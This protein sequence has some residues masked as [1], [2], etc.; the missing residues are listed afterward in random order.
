MKNRILFSLAALLLAMFVGGTA[1]GQ[2]NIIISDTYDV[3]SSTTG[4]A[5]NN[6][7]NFG[8]DPPTTRMTGPAAADLRYIQTATDKPA[9]QY[10][11]PSTKL[12]RILADTGSGK[13]GR[14]TLSA[15]GT[16]PFNFASALGLA[17]ASPTNRA[18]Y[19]IKISMQNNST[20]TAKLSFG[21]GTVEGNV[22]SF[23]FGIQI[24]RVSGEN[25]YSLSKLIDNASS[26][27]GDIKVAVT[28]LAAGTWKTLVPF[29]IRV[30]DAGAEAGTNYHSRVRVSIDNGTN[31]IYDTATDAALTNGWRLDGPGRVIIWDQAGNTGGP[32]YYDNFSLV[33]NYAPPAPPERVWTGAG[34][35]DNW[36][37]GGNWG[38]TAP[39]SGEPLLFGL[40][41]RQANFNDLTLTT[42]SLTFSNGGFSLSGN[43]LEVE[44][45]I[46]NL[47]GN[48]TIGLALA[49]PLPFAKTWQL[50]NGT[51]LN[52]SGF[53]TLNIGGDH[54]FY[55]GGTLRITGQLDIGP[56][57]PAINLTEG[58]FVVDGGTF[59]SDGG[60]R[61]GSGNIATAP[62]EV[63]VTNGASL[64]LRL[65]AGNLRVG[66][67]ATAAPSRLIVN[68]GTVDMAAGRMGI[69][70]AAG[71][72]AEVLQTGGLVTDCY[73][74]FNDEGA[75]VGT[76][77]VDGGTLEPW[78]IRKDNS[79][80]TTTMRFN[81][82]ILRPAAGANANFM[83]GLNVAEIQ[84]G[85]LT[86]DA[87]YDPV[88]ISQKLVGAGGLSKS[89]SGAVTLSGANTYAGDTLVLPGGGKL[90]LP[91]VQSNTASIQVADGTELGVLQ[92]AQN[93][94]LAAASLALGSGILSFDLG[95]LGNP[96]APLAKV[97]TLS[98]S[99]GAGSVQVNVSGG[100]GVTPGQFTL[101]DYSGAIS[102]GFSSFTLGTLPPGVTATLV[103]NV[104]NSSIDLNITLAPG[105]VWKG[106]NGSSWDYGTVNWLDYGTAANGLY[107]DNLPTWFLDGAATGIVNL[108][109]AFTPGL[110]TVNNDS[111]AYV[112]TGGA[113]STPVLR[114]YGDN[115]LVRVNGESDAIPTLELNAGSYVVSNATAADFKS[116]LRDE[117]GAT[118]TFVKRGVGTLTVLS[119]SPTYHGATMIQEGIL[120]LGDTRSLGAATALI[121]ITNGGTLD[122]V[123][124]QPKQPVI[125]SGDGTGGVG[126]IIDSTTDGGVEENFLD[127]A[128]AG[129]TTFGCPNAGRWDIRVNGGL[130]GTGPGPGLKGNGYKL[131][132]VGSGS[133]SIACQRS[134]TGYWDLNLGDVLIKEGGLTFAESLTPGNSAA[135]LAIYPGANL[136]LFD[137]NITNPLMRNITMTNA[138]IQC[139]GERNHTNVIQGN[140]LMSGNCRFQADDAHLII[141]GSI[142]GAASVAFNEDGPTDTG[143][144]L[145]NGVNTYTGETTIT[146]GTL[147]GTGVLAGNLVMLG[148]TNAP[149]YGGVGTLTVN[150]NV[151][152]AG[153]TRM[154]LNRGLSPNSDRL[155]VGGALT[156]GGALRVVLGAGA[157]A[158]EA[159]DVYQLFSKG[160]AAPFTAVS[161]PDLS[162]LPG[163]LTWDT[164]QLQID[165]SISVAGGA[166]PPPIGTVQINGGNFTLS[167][168]GG[169]EGAGYIVISSPDVTVPL[170]NWTPVASGVYGAGG[171]FS[172][173]TNVVTGGP[174][175]FFTLKKP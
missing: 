112:W 78:Q 175:L 74:V 140:I 35:D 105:L 62:V 11:I 76:Y 161:L 122:V 75:G 141:N 43:Q 149:G 135:A 151:T 54:T 118:G 108:A 116:V 21:L 117:S 85:G 47:V 159:G 51:E 9:S 46:N 15:N 157:P 84:S 168:T 39:V 1:F 71:C 82:A 37:T 125:V 66:D 36:S 30:N 166:P 150:G 89:G 13:I 65:S 3:S 68:N 56:A 155:V 70:Y 102:G 17:G 115:A 132:K 130:N 72:T 27:V 4:F 143:T 92:A 59:S 93:A 169:V 8:I 121:V 2:T 147:G 48:N 79:G 64:V 60:F 163:G 167:G 45:D 6:G 170:A 107:A 22:D 81:N 146:N 19:D 58:K 164:T 77:V 172:F 34:T 83:S 174:T 171:S 26:G 111:L 127:V 173:T 165:G 80:G 156:F 123:D 128:L 99:G 124:H 24:N 133:V 69:P 53:S 7:V 136:N 55:G 154:E 41:A 96:T 33:S 94:S 144:L 52:L 14:F 101:V 31:W 97:T 114:K 18:E 12:I 38:G 160:S 120:K 162:G 16:T 145:L 5:L 20:G 49:W 109:G 23:D 158:P 129:D 86:I 126:A 42:P 153:V 104:A 10:N 50:A 139:G 98:A 95:A 131:S 44:S 29:L 152:L 90:V 110:L 25:Y 137:L 134:T 73:I 148:G 119:N 57:T 63:V 87:L 88:A 32:T 40:S 100:V 28:D 103:D 91:N 106:L 61:I 138:L 113:I 142:S 67:G